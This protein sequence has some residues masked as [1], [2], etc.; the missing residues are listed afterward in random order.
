MKNSDVLIWRFTVVNHFT[1]EQIDEVLAVGST[2]HAAEVH[3]RNLFP[4]ALYDI[5]DCVQ[6]RN[7]SLLVVGV[8]NYSSLLS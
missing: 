3:L 6:V 5:V 1:F 4:S 8:S 2:L 7:R